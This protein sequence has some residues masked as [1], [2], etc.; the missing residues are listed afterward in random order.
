[1]DDARLAAARELLLEERPDLRDDFE[2]G[3]IAL[4]DG[5]FGSVR[6]VR[7][8]TEIVDPTLN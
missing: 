6:V 4:L 2:A 8:E 1:M 7:I 3:H 5:D